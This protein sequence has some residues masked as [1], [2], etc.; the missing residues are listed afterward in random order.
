MY[1][2]LKKRYIMLVSKNEFLNSHLEGDLNH[3]LPFKVSLSLIRK[4]PGPFPGASSCLSASFL[5]MSLKNHLRRHCYISWMLCSREG[6]RYEC[7]RKP[8]Q[9]AKPS[10]MTMGKDSLFCFQGVDFGDVVAGDE[11]FSLCWKGFSFPPFSMP[12]R[13]TDIKK[14]LY[15]GAP[16]W[17]CW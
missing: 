10:K 5:V 14:H 7:I 15:P 11:P 16:G 9:Q 1:L 2:F 6:K 12:G 13:E 17:L 8:R 4:A 3:F